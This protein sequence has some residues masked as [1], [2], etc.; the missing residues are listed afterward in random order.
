MPASLGVGEDCMCDRRIELGGRH[1]APRRHAV[2]IGLRDGGL[3][4]KKAKR[5][6]L[7]AVG[8]ARQLEVDNVMVP[9]EQR[10]RQPARLLDFVGHRHEHRL[11]AS[12]RAITAASPASSGDVAMIAQVSFRLAESTP[13]QPDRLRSS[14]PD[15]SVLS[16]CPSSR[17]RTGN[18]QRRPSDTSSRD[19][20]RQ[21]GFA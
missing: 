16:T 18:R 4:R 1:S 19:R 8:R 21:P 11:T 17:Y 9:V 20:E 13:S 15:Q 14:A 6:S 7:D 10:R 2:G 5:I 3:T 12:A